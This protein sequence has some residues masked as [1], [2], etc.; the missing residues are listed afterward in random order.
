MQ[1]RVIT[2]HH[3]VSYFLRTHPD[4]AWTSFVKVWGWG[5]TVDHPKPLG[6]DVFFCYSLGRC[7]SFLFRG[8]WPRITIFFEKWFAFLSNCS[9]IFHTT[10]FI[11]FQYLC[12]ICRSVTSQFLADYLISESFVKAGL[13]LKLSLCKFLC[14]FVPKTKGT[15]IQLKYLPLDPQ[16]HEKWRF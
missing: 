2:L 10:T 6:I 16:N 13:P 8:R 5:W 1:E 11:H 3:D 14:F 9:S 15:K 4:P 7:C 12:S